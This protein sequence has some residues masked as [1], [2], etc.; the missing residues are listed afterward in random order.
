[1]SAKKGGSSDFFFAKVMPFVYGIGAAVVI[2]GALFKIMHWPGASEMLIVGLGTEAAIFFLSAF[3]PQHA[4]PDWTR[5]YPELAED[6]KGELPQRRPEQKEKG[7]G[8]TAKLDDMLTNAKVGPELINSLGSGMK[9]LA[10]TA[11]KLNNLTDASV[12]TNEY[13]QNVKKASGALVD[14]N[15]SYATT[16]TAMA[17]MSNA[18]QDAKSY[19]A[20]VQTVTKNLGALNAVYEME[21]QDTNKHL[22]AM[23]SFYGSLSSAMENM[24]QASKDT[25]QFK[26]E[27]T[28]LTTNLTT[29]NKVYGSMLTAMKG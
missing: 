19:H 18:A 27:L 16:V 23:Q 11:S 20:Q 7:N 22:K 13:A 2:V 8:L 5:V 14:M 28:K 4:D 1:M 10:E 3:A 12:A 29:L 24:A 6:F 25:E 17:E 26:G 21:L 15:K 9:S